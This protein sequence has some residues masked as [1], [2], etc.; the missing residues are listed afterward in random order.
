MVD[1]HQKCCHSRC[2]IG[3]SVHHWH[4]LWRLLFRHNDKVITIIDHSSHSANQ[5][6]PHSKFGFAPKFTHWPPWGILGEV[7]LYSTSNVFRSFFWTLRVGEG[8]IRK[9]VYIKET[10]DRKN[11]KGP[12][13]LQKPWALPRF[14]KGKLQKCQIWKN[15]R[16]FVKSSNR[17]IYL[18]GLELK[19]W[20]SSYVILQLVFFPPVPGQ[21]KPRREAPRSAKLLPFAASQNGDQGRPAAQRSVMLALAA[22]SL[23]QH[24]ST[25]G[26]SRKPQ[27]QVCHDVTKKIP[28]ALQD[29]QP[30]FGAGRLFY[31]CTMVG[32]I[33]FFNSF[34][35]LSNQ[36]KKVSTNM[37]ELLPHSAKTLH[38]KAF[39]SWQFPCTQLAPADDLTVLD[40]NWG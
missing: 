6:H 30:K 33:S 29:C 17:W 3:H 12:S 31:W 11:Q 4:H 23:E 14:G 36:T 21:S 37:K 2:I 34:M 35:H 5:N 18:G 9:S 32:Y 38:L 27:A 10:I 25:S 22:S 20:Y 7:S 26:K 28:R 13:N 24:R 16:N 1:T 8:H 40:T 15:S 19:P 39:S